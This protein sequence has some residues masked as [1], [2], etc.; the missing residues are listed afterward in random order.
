MIK[1]KFI[2]KDL[3]WLLGFTTALFG[4]IYSPKPLPV[5]YY[6]IVAIG[7]ILEVGKLRYELK[8]KR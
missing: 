4:I 2:L 5:L 3:W 6:L 1:L 8:V 7:T